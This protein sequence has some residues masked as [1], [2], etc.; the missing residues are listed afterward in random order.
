VKRDE[1][2]KSRD[3]MVVDNTKDDRT[4]KLYVTYVTNSGCPLLKRTENVF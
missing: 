2:V 4:I 1:I 3:E